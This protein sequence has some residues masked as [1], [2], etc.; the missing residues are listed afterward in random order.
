MEGDIIGH[1]GLLHQ[2]AQY[3]LQP[4]VQSVPEHCTHRKHPQHSDQLECSLAHEPV[5][6]SS[7]TPADMTSRQPAIRTSAPLP[8]HKQVPFMLDPVVIA[9]LVIDGSA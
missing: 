6:F 5:H 2:E 9:T 4:I 1:L 8:V 3:R 7:N